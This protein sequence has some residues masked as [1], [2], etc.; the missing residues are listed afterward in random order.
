MTRS[1]TFLTFCFLGHP[2]VQR[3]GEDEDIGFGMWR[4]DS[5]FGG[6]RMDSK[7]RFGGWRTDSTVGGW[8]TE[9]RVGGWRTETRVRGWI[10]DIMFGGEEERKRGSE[11]RG[12]P[13]SSGVGE[14]TEYLV[15]AGEWEAGLGLGS[16]GRAGSAGIGSIFRR[17]SSAFQK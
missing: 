8:R 3:L 2:L 14:R 5:T 16:G 15:E 9:T 13:V 7:F 6:R 4:G 17:V 11:V 1:V 10:I 12:R